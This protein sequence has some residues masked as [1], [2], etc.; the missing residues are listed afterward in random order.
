MRC[1]LAQGPVERKDI[2]AGKIGSNSCEETDASPVNFFAGYFYLTTYGVKA[3]TTKHEA[4]TSRLYK[5]SQSRAI[6]ENVR[7]V[8][9]SAPNQS[10]LSPVYLEDNIYSGL[11]GGWEGVGVPNQHILERIS[12]IGSNRRNWNRVSVLIHSVIQLYLSCLFFTL[13]SNSAS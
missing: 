8:F 9:R 3:K 7:I 10:Q 2:F 4:F 12:L 1:S 13:T 11:V 5:L 6:H